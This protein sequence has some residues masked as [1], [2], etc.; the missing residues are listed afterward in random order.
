M[1]AAPTKMAATAYLVYSWLADISTY[2][3][4]YNMAT[5]FT[6]TA[7]ALDRTTSDGI[8]YQVHMRL[9]AA[10]DTYQT[11]ASVSVPLDL[12]AEGDTVVPYSELTE[13]VVVGWSK[14]KLGTEQ[15]TAI[16]SELQRRLNEQ[17][18]PTTA[19][20]TPWS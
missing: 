18:T 17:R 13:E 7:D 12:P 4:F 3:F 16:E 10:D 20:G 9:N 1:L 19:T 8:V 11:A 6:W 14:A 5:T 2:V 15:V